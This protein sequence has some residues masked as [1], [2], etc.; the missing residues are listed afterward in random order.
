MLSSPRGR[1]AQARVNQRAVDAEGFAKQF[2]SVVGSSVMTFGFKDLTPA[3]IMTELLAKAAKQP[4]IGILGIKTGSLGHA[5]N[6]QID[7][8][9]KIYRLIDDNVGV[10]EFPSAE[11]FK[12]EAAKLLSILYPGI[13]TAFLDY[14]AK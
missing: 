8:K 14:P 2:A 3:G 1:I 13:H 5:I 6:I 4:L 7:P 9:N 10:L 12:E 11:L